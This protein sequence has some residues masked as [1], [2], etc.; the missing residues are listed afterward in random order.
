MHLEQFYSNFKIEKG[1]KEHAFRATLQQ[2]LMPWKH[3]CWKNMLASPLGVQNRYLMNA[4]ASIKESSKGYGGK[5][6]T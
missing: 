2:S 6:I 3:E 1:T 4:N 5:S